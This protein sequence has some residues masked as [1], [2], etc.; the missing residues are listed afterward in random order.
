[1]KEI[2]INVTIHRAYLIKLQVFNA[3]SR[4]V[5][6]HVTFSLL[7]PKDHTSRNWVELIYRVTNSMAIFN[8]VMPGCQAQKTPEKRQPMRNTITTFHETIYPIR[9]QHIV[10]RT[11]EA[12]PLFQREREES[13]TWNAKIQLLR[14]YIYLFVGV[15]LA[16]K[17]LLVFRFPET[18]SSLSDDAPLV[19]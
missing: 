9:N 8:E 19:N 10:N 11:N 17:Q 12:Q 18:S 5:V 14:K 1:M 3:V 2:C 16:L 13:Q 7:I 15:G 4:D 6:Q